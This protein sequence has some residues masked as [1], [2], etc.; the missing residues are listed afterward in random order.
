M[1]DD[2]EIQAIID[3][4]KGRVAAAE[5]ADRRGPTLRATDELAEAEAR[6]GDGIHP[7]IDAAVDAA[8]KAF[9]AY[10]DMGLDARKTVVESMRAA[11][12]RE[13]ERLA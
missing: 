7:N 8:K 1:L 9:L 5:Q 6:L 13:G 11:M 4:V 2:R 12:L 3:R 10:R